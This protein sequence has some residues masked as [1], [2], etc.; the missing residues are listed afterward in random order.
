MCRYRNKHSIHRVW[1]CPYR[2]F[3]YLLGVLE[4]ITQEGG[5]FIFQMKH[6]LM[7][8]RFNRDPL[9]N[10]LEYTLLWFRSVRVKI[11]IIYPIHT[12]S[13]MIKSANP[14]A[15][16]ILVQKRENKDILKNFSE[17]FW[18]PPQLNVK[19]SWIKFQP[20]NGEYIL[21]LFMFIHLY[22]WVPQLDL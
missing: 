19:H 18:N 14:T 13:T 11:K 20:W 22:I 1:Y 2:G 6:E 16:V 3:R 5:L 4:C 9:R 12:L 10:F 17:K 8:I 21:Q 7:W 15:I